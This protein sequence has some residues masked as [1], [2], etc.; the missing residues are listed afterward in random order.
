VPRERATNPLVDLA[1]PVGK[2]DPKV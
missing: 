1:A 2:A